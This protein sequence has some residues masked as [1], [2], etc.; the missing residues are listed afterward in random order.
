V[1]FV[2]DELLKIGM[3]PHVM[4]AMDNEPSKALFAKLGFEADGVQNCWIHAK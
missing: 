4:A 1:A 3:T 2:A